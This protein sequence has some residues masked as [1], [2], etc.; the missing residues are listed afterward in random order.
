MTSHKY[1]T[2][3][4]S[5]ILKNA[6]IMIEESLEILQAISRC[7]PPQSERPQA[8]RTRSSH[9]WRH[10][11]L[12]STGVRDE[13]PTAHISSI[14]SLLELREITEDLQDSYARVYTRHELNDALNFL[15]GL[16]EPKI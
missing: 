13:H 3:V 10:G 4:R 15:V 11:G 16:T 1:K 7:L 9:H 8:S 5:L 12:R 14:I 6:T 2:G